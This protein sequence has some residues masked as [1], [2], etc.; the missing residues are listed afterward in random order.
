LKKGKSKGKE[1]EKV[2]EEEV[3]DEVVV[4]KAVFPSFHLTL[5]QSKCRVCKRGDDEDKLV[6]CDGY[7]YSLVCVSIF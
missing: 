2:T 7:T 4:R 5:T 6:L 1:K 3:E